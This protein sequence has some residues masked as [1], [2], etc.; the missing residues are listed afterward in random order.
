MFKNIPNELKNIP[1][2][3]CWKAYPDANSHSGIKKVPINP[4]TGGQ[5]MSNNPQTWSSYE[6]AVRVAQR[7][8]GI[9]FMFSNSGFFGIDLDDCRNE[10]QAYLGGDKN[11]IVA[12]FIGQMQTY[13][14]TSQSGNGIHLICSGNLPISGRRKGKVEMYDSGRFFIMTGNA[15]GGY[16]AISNGTE[17][18]KPLHRKYFGTT[19]Q[20]TS[21]PAPAPV[22]ATPTLSDHELIEKILNSAN[23]D[24][25]SALYGGD[26]SD[27]PSQSEADMA[28]CSILAFW[29]GGDKDAMDRIYRSSNLMRE[30]WDRKQCGSTYGAITL[31]RA[32]ENCQSFYQPPVEDDYHITIKNPTPA[33]SPKLPMHTLDDTGNA[34]RM[35]DYCGRVFRYNYTDKRW[36]YYKGGVWVYDDRG[37]IFTAADV[38]LERM[39]IELKSWTEHEGGAYLQD[40]QKHMKKTRS[41]AAKTAMVKEFQHI[42]P[43][44]LAELDTHKTLVNTQN[45][46][47]DL[48]TCT[49]M[50]HSPEMLMTRMLGTSMPA[51]PKNP[52]LWLRFLD[53]VFG[54]DKEL[55]RYIQ[56]SLGYCLSGSTAEQCVFFLYGNGRN[57]KSTFL[58][59][60]RAIL[61]EYATNIQ[62]E[63]IMVKNSNSSANTD[64]ARLKGARLVT[65]VEPNEGMRLNEGLIKQLTGDDMVTA[66]KLY[67]D[68]FEYRPEFKLWLA[69]NHKPTIRGTDLGIWRRIHI[70]PF[71]KCIPEDK[72]DKNLGEKLREEMPDI[73]AW[74]MEGYRLWKY[75]GLHKPKAVED[76]VKEYRTEMDVIA[77]FLDSDYCMDGGEAKASSLYAVYC[78]WAG[79]SNEYKMSSRKFGIEMGKRYKKK[80]DSKGNITYVGLSLTS[81]SISNG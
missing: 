53:D 31:S 80:K 55:I 19:Q 36:M 74:M 6:T 7:Y 78:R 81:I 28:F 8:D 3:V 62:P 58:E 61:G 63:S 17:R 14:E 4:H 64:I 46:I 45:G 72:V 29:C 73:L 2:W 18:I 75:E 39:K 51:K 25:F 67:G 69:T 56:K 65:S 12:E 20:R 34:E 27:Y 10:I 11:N 1:N 32:V 13:A 52:V 47:V 35:N 24:K 76:S 66:R 38:I 9:G 59:I 26:F 60:I 70:I 68:E 23:G 49:T 79:E 37:A 77:A 30:K 71:V 16:T 41:N 48:D 43:I 50:P 57:G 15:I 44:S 33:P 54:D 5:A 21:T 42:V 22:R 40:Y